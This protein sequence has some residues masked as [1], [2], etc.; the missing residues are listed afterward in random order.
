MSVIRS[1]A[2]LTFWSIV[3]KSNPS[4]KRQILTT[5]ILLSGITPAKRGARRHMPAEVT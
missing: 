5:S 3:N 4:T 2:W 1:D